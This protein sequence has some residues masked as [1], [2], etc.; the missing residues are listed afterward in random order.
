MVVGHQ[1]APMPGFVHKLLDIGPVVPPGP[2]V[3]QMLPLL[4][5]LQGHI[6]AKVGVKAH[7][8]GVVGVLGQQVQVDLWPEGVKGS[9]AGGPDIGLVACQQEKVRGGKGGVVVW[10]LVVGNGQDG[11]ACLPVCLHQL[12]RGKSAI[13]KGGVGMQI[14]TVLLC[15][16]GNVREHSM[17]LSREQKGQPPWAALLAIFA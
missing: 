6:L 12:F 7:D 16:G 8:G 14:G 17:L 10:S 9:S 15:L 1:I 2:Q 5:H 11:V 4:C 3:A 13:R